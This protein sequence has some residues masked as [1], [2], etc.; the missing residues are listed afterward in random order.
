MKILDWLSWRVVRRTFAT[1]AVRGWTLEAT[2]LR[3]L[4][5]A[6]KPSAKLFIFG[7]K[8][9]SVLPR[10]RRSIYFRRQEARSC[11]IRAASQTIVFASARKFE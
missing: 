8:E 7:N 4:R 10:Q 9:G 5:A 3:G 2:E 1:R 6:Q 11:D